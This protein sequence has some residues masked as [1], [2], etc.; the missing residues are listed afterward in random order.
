MLRP[1]FELENV[2][3][4]AFDVAT[5]LYGITFEEV[6]RHPEVS[7]GRPRVRGE[8]GGRRRTSVSC[9]W[10]ISRGRASAGG[11][12]M[13]AYK[14]EMQK[15][16]KAH[17]AGDRQLRELLEADRR[18]AGAPELGRSDDALPRVRPRAARAALR[19][20]PTRASRGPTSRR[21][22]SSCRRRSW[23][24][25]PPSRRCSRST[26]ST[27][28]PASRCPTT[29]SRRSR[30]PGTSTRASR[31][32]STWPRRI[33]D[34]DWHTLAEPQARRS[35]RSSR[36]R[37]MRRIGLIPEIVVAVPEP[38]LQPH[39]R[40]RL[41]GRVL[42][43]HLGGGARRRRFPGVQGE[44]TLRPGRPRSVPREH[45]RRGGDRGSR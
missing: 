1:Y 32:P 40:R 33:L 14:D 28:R 11:A 19:T 23:R 15:D 7:R 13:G 10:T 34:M 16:G 35:D 5:K 22:S 26:R 31:R 36:T 2:R 20:A 44:G 42:Q 8:G 9:T 30:R 45:P 41:L 24:T 3:Q 21:I 29:S 37:R 4:G 27:T 12:W 6:D 43:L 17:R 39:L 25:G 18:Q 38:V